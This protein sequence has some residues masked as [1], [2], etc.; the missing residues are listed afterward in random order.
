MNRRNL[1]IG[2]LVAG[3]LALPLLAAAQGSSTPSSGA[4]AAK[5]APSAMQAQAATPAQ[6]TATQTT[7]TK[8][9]TSTGK[10]SMHSSS[11]PKLDLNGATREE[12][13][14][15]PGVGEATADKIIAARP[16]KSKNELVSKKLVSQSEYNKIAAHVIAKQ[17]AVASK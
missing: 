4:E 17:P 2:S 13:I 12:L 7:A 11:V 15:L 5:P 6:H 8:S 9:T 1:V 3:L 10:S 14:K 16:F